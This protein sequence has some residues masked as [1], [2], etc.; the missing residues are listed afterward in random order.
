MPGFPDTHL[1]LIARLKD[2]GDQQA[3]RQFVDIYR[4]VVY[5]LAR[6]PSAILMSLWRV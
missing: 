2:W 5:R 6:V 4:P 1:S 3:W